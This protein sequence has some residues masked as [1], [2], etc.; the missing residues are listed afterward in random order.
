MIAA[1]G[2]HLVAA[3]G[4]S[5]DET[6]MMIQANF[7]DGTGSSEDSEVLS[8]LCFCN[9]L[10]KGGLLLVGEVVEGSLNDIPGGAMGRGEEGNDEGGGG[11]ESA[12]RARRTRAGW[13]ASLERMELK[14]IPTVVVAASTLAGQ[15]HLLCTAG[16]GGMQVNTIVIALPKPQIMPKPKM[17]S[18][19][20]PSPTG[21]N[22]SDGSPK[23]AKRIA[24]TV[25]SSGFGVDESRMAE[26]STV[27]PQSARD[28]VSLLRSVAAV[29]KNVV[30]LRH[31]DS[32]KLDPRLGLGHTFGPSGAAVPC[33]PSKRSAFS[34]LRG[35]ATGGNG[36]KTL[37]VYFTITAC[38]AGE[39]FGGEDFAHE[40]EVDA[41]N[42]RSYVV[43]STCTAPCL[44]NNQPSL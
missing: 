5:R 14:A 28:L 40:L 10:K 19:V 41:F 11:G 7:N 24:H 22:G 6:T 30:L 12:K 42:A 43:S 8:M 39:S 27:D 3:A 21:S 26:G 16:L 4:D 34:P 44:T 13:A 29:K 2:D 35:K 31:F 37:D 1:A 17:G 38:R 25:L 20:A 33:N 23:N 32:S 15:E 36:A 9:L 18:S